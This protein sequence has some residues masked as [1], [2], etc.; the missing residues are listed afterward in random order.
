MNQYLLI[1]D[2][3][4]GAFGKV[5]LV[6]NMEDNS[7][8]ALKM[9]SKL[10]AKRGSLQR[11]GQKQE[12]PNSNALLSEINVMKSLQHPNVVRLFEVVLLSLFL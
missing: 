4:D 6:L 2:I 1:K 3:G 9:V 11:R 10:Q 5:K 7:L 12:E 8:Y